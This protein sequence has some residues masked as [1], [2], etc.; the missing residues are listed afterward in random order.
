ME[1]IGRKSTMELELLK[2][3][4]FVTNP[5]E[6][7]CATI[8][9]P[10]GVGK[11]TLVKHWIAEWDAQ[12]EKKDVCLVFVDLKDIDTTHEIAFWAFWKVVL[13]TCKEKADLT[14]KTG[15][16][17]KRIEEATEY[18]LSRENEMLCSDAD[19]YVYLKLLFESYAKLQFRVILVIDHFEHA[20]SLFPAES[21]GGLFFQTLFSYSNKG[22]IL[23]KGLNILLLSNGDVDTIAHHMA[24]GSIFSTAYPMVHLDGF[25]ESEMDCYYNFFPGITD[26]QK[27]RIAWYCGRHPLLLEK[28][29]E[30]LLKHGAEMGYDIDKLYLQY[31]EELNSL[32][33]DFYE[34]VKREGFQE[35]L[36]TCQE[37]EEYRKELYLQGLMCREPEESMLLQTDAGNGSIK[38]E[39]IAPYL[40]EYVKHL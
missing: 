29:H 15:L 24:M 10:G 7:R 40:L 33:S 6:I 8:C 5:G 28:M 27:E 31:G 11:S 4:I 19:A 25:F 26:G 2:K 13:N 32:Y 16:S 17:K 36:L 12:K 9:G 34:R 39:L 14:Q 30:M 21:D 1:H 23:K 3:E 38:Y 37:N 20:E 18:I 22:S 35:K